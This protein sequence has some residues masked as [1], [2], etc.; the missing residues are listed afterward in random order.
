[1]DSNLGLFVCLPLLTTVDALPPGGLVAL[2]VHRLYHIALWYLSTYVLEYVLLFCTPSPTLEL[3]QTSL[4]ICKP[5]LTET[6][7]VLLVRTTVRWLLGPPC[8]SALPIL[9]HPTPAVS[10][11][12]PTGPASPVSTCLRLE[13]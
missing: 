7:M 13:G 8:L 4:P 10:C 5:R 11:F 6:S 3:N 1:M 12:T 2:V 9:S